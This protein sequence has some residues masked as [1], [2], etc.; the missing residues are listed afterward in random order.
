MA[1]TTE[2]TNVHIRRMI[3]EV[4]PGAEIILFGSRAR[5]SEAKTSDY[6]LL[7][8]IERPITVA[9]RMRCQSQI[10]KQLANH[11]ILADVLVQSR[12]EV[13]QKKQLIGHIIRSAMREGIPL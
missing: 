12:I 8:I 2:T 10:R 3:L 9:E 6:D 7:V 11:S 5:G 4:L 1:A 13:D